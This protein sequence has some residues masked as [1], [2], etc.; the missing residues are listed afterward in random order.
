MGGELWW[1]RNIPVLAETHR[2]VV[3]DFRGHG[4][5]GKGDEGHT[6]AQYAR[7]VRLLLE[8]LDPGPVTPVG[9]SMGT[10]VL[11][12]YVEQFGCEG[13]RSVVL[14]DQSPRDLVAPDWPF[15]VSGRLTPEALAG[16]AQSLRHARAATLRGII[17]ENCQNRHYQATGKFLSQVIRAKLAGLPALYAELAARLEPLV[18]ANRV[19]INLYPDELRDGAG[20]F[21]DDI[22]NYHGVRAIRANEAKWMFE[23]FMTPLNATI[24]VAAAAHG[25]NVIA[26]APQLFRTHGYCAGAGGWVVTYDQSSATQGNTNGTMHPNPAGHAVMG[27]LAA[28]LLVRDLFGRG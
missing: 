22:I 7:D 10:S 24:V 1:R 2:V 12:R 14:V 27:A 8:A 18:A 21:C 26:G 20:A 9:W 19:Y 17:N 5:S 6:L 3:L 13:F 23:D 16:M 4:L 15:A 25:W 11:L 28:K